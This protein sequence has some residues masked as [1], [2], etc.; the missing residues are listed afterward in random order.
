MLFNRGGVGCILPSPPWIT[1]KEINISM[2]DIVP[3]MDTF[4]ILQRC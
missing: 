3:E 2:K 4:I 1:K